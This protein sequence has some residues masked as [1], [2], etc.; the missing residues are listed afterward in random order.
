M[1]EWKTLA[2]LAE[3]NSRFIL[4]FGIAFVGPL[5]L[6]APIEPVAFQLTGPGG[7]GKTSVGAVASSIWGQRTLGGKPHPLGAGDAW[8]N[9]LN[10]LER[11][12]ATRDHTFLFLD[13]AH[14]ARPEDIVAAI[15]LISEGQGRGRYTEVS[16]W[17]WFVPMLSTS[18]DSVAEIL[19]K[20]R[21]TADR[22]AFDR[23][24]DVPL[25]TGRFGAFENLHG[26][27]TVGDFV[28]RLKAI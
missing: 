3:G 18:N 8:N 6:I 17:E 2:A 26:S 12:L 7:T 19:E 11:V 16:R 15:F 25:P 27:D 22:A 9:T 10:N 20:A 28:L 5:R 4:A 21:E 24:I 23:L 14:L 13:E 1:K